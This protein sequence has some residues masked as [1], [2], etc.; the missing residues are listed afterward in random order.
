MKR[1]IQEWT[2]EAL[3]KRRTYHLPPPRR[4][5][6]G[7]L[8]WYASRRHTCPAALC[9]FQGSAIQSPRTCHRF[10]CDYGW[11][12][13]KRKE[14]SS[15]P[16][17]TH[18]LGFLFSKSQINTKPTVTPRSRVLCGPAGIY[19]IVRK[20]WEVPMDTGS[21]QL[22]YSLSS[23]P[24]RKISESSF[25]TFYPSLRPLYSSPLPFP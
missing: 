19:L 4:P 14:A 8:W 17:L 11:K 21:Q 7:G 16:F 9:P 23:L 25:P 3:R 13:S 20:K 10:S 6:K 2:S 22:S 15:I 5:E 18:P 12:T 1:N 24:L